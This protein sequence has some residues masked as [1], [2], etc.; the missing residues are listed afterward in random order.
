ML[1]DPIISIATQEIFS[2]GRSRYNISADIKSKEAAIEKLARKYG[3]S[4]F[5]P[6]L[7]KQ[8]LY[9]IGDNHAFLRSN[10]DPCDRMISNFIK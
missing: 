10:R 3:R 4:D 8:C 9:S 7:V 6:E 2:E 1:S 5:L